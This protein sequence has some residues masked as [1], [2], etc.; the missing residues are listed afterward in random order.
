MVQP[1]LTPKIRSKKAMQIDRVLQRIQM[2]I[3]LL[4]ISLYGVNL[5]LFGLSGELILRNT[6]SFVHPLIQLNPA[7]RTVISFDLTT[8]CILAIILACVLQLIRIAAIV[9]FDRGGRGLKLGEAPL[10]GGAVYQVFLAIIL[11]VLLL[12]TI[13]TI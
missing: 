6:S 5:L 7:L 8:S 13:R 9:H 2:S 1:V 4:A 10:D 3:G 11:T 12:V